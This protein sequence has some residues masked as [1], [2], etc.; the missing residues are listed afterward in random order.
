[1]G[2]LQSYLW[3]PTFLSRKSQNPTDPPGT[4]FISK[5]NLRINKWQCTKRLRLAFPLQR[6][7]H[8]I[9]GDDIVPNDS[10]I[11]TQWGVPGTQEPRNPGFQ[12]PGR[13]QSHQMTRVVISHET[14]IRSVNRQIMLSS[15]KVRHSLSRGMFVPRLFRKDTIAV[16][17]YTCLAQICRL[18]QTYC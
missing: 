4:T 17:R 13:R 18:D 15:L 16:L 12:N 7:H 1:M 8:N 3:I 14:V 5:R 9:F 6:L 2:P 10:V 11:F